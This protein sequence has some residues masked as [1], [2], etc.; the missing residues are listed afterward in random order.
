MELWTYNK[1]FL[2]QKEHSKEAYDYTVSLISTNAYEGIWY[3]QQC[4]AK[5]NTLELL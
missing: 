4:P 1:H 3:S 2:V 5:V